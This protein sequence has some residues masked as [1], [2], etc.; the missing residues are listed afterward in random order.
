MGI[1]RLV[2]ALAVVISH[3]ST[4]LNKTAVPGT[5]AVQAFFIISGYYIALILDRKYRFAGGTRLFYQQR[6]LRLAPMYWLAILGTLGAGAFY[7]VLS[8]H[9][10]GIFAILAR[11]GAHLSPASIAVLCLTQVTMLGQDAMIFFS[12]SGQ[13]LALRFTPYWPAGALPAERFLL[14]PVAWSLSVELLFYLS[15]PFLV[16]RSVRFQ[17]ALVSIIFALRAF[18]IS[19][20]S[21][22]LFPWNCRFFL[23]EAAL[24]LLGSVAY[25]LLPRAENLVRSCRSLRP[26]I[27]T[28]MAAAILCYNWIPLPDEARHWSFLALIAM[29]IPLL[30]AATQRDR[31]DR[32]IA[33]MSYPLYLLHQ[34]TLFAAEPLLRRTS[35]ITNEFVVLLL[36]LGTAALAYSLIERPFESWRARRYERS[37]AA[38]KWQASQM[39]ETA[40]NAGVA[41]SSPGS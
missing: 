9:P 41:L 15:A 39:L 10:A 32:W 5:V 19:H 25:R 14:S 13:P 11:H 2:L 20:W 16:R 1:L 35:G 3:T 8:H 33:E 36:P 18:A 28:V 30:F 26:V 37:V 12:M 7:T 24:F 29:S 22:A 4:R 21:L 6:Y 27:T 23:F 34:V 38:A 31:V 40:P 17:L